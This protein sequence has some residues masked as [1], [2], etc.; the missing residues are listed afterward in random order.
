M[1]CWCQTKGT[2]RW[3]EGSAEVHLSAASKHQE[4]P[5]A[6]AAREGRAEWQWQVTPLVDARASGSGSDTVH[7]RGFLAVISGDKSE[8]ESDRKPPLSMKQTTC[9]LYFPLN[10]SRAIQRLEMELSVGWKAFHDLIQNQ[11]KGGLSKD[12]LFGVNSV[13]VLVIGAP[14]SHR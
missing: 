8:K 5:L 2:R 7:R 4:R 11:R 1:E 14:R 10:I 3:D 13:P 6:L 12:L 9:P